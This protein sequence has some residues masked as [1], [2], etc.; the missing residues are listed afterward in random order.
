MDLQKCVK[1][2]YVQVHR[3]NRDMAVRAY[4][5]AFVGKRSNTATIRSRQPAGDDSAV[6]EEANGEIW[7]ALTEGNIF[8]ILQELA[9][10]RGKMVMRVFWYWPRLERHPEEMRRAMLMQDLLNRRACES[11]TAAGSPICG[12]GSPSTVPGS[13]GSGGSAGSLDGEGV[14]V[15]L[16]EPAICAHCERVHG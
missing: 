1:M 16:G 15:D 2:P 13:P 5:L 11:A 4:S 3:G 9:Q 10:G 7:I 6:K 8:V 12:P 14:G